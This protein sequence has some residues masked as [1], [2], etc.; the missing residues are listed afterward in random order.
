MES[1]SKKQLSG[2]NVNTYCDTA[3]LYIAKDAGTHIS[4]RFRHN[5]I[6]ILGVDIV[7][8][9]IA[10]W[11]II[12]NYDVR[13]CLFML[14]LLIVF[15]LLDI[16]VKSRRQY[17]DWR[18]NG[19]F[20][21]VDS[22]GINRMVKDKNTGRF[23]REDD[24]RWEF[25]A[26]VKFYDD[27]VIVAKKVQKL[28]I[29]ERIYMRSENMQRD[30]CA[31][32]TFWARSLHGDD[33]YTPD[34]YSEEDM[35]AM[36]DFINTRFGKSEGVFH[37]WV[38]PDI[39]MDIVIIPPVKERNYYTLCTMGAGTYT[40]NVLEAD[41]TGNN[42]ADH[43]EYMIYLPADWDLS[44]EGLKD[45]R[46]YWPIRQLK[47]AARGPIH[48]H[49]YMAWGHTMGYDNG[50]PFA[51]NSAFR[52]LL[53]LSPAPDV[54]KTLSCNLPSGITVEIFQL[55]P[56][57]S[58]ELA[59]KKGKHGAMNLLKAIEA[60]NQEDAWTHFA[61]KRLK[62]MQAPYAPHPDTEPYKFFQEPYLVL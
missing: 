47:I 46:N 35:N 24:I 40:M 27:Y 9:L 6:N 3:K 57:T 42:I 62:Q 10:I 14:A 18:K 43:A 59:V 48:S 31:I 60:T 54:H 21:R 22:S 19:A 37:E 11:L 45:E 16:F 49:E 55:F 30:K 34:V 12:S 7:L 26:D 32:L 8:M 17:S 5:Y 61:V 53:L 15:T 50:A 36:E 4:K 51:F 33:V 2:I 52:A 38:S 20:Y 39:H 25:V 56:I 1:Y 28:G 23:V 29:P 44:E 41:R 58:D 13:L